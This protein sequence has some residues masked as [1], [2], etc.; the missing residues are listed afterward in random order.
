[1][2]SFVAG[3]HDKLVEI[4]TMLDENADKFFGQMGI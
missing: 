4:K 2:A 1:V 3:D